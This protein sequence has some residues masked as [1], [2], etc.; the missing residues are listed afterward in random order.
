[1]STVVYDGRN[2]PVGKLVESGNQI[3]AYSMTGKLLGYYD[4]SND[5]TMT[6]KNALHSRG[7]SVRSLLF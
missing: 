3:Q 2:I 6:Q 7:N 1:M 5:R 4:K